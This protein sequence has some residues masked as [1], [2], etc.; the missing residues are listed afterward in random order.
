VTP[1]PAPAPAD[2]PHLPGP[3]WLFCPADRPDRFTKA[4][5]RAD[6]VI[7]D[8]EDAVAADRKDL[9]RRAVLDTP[10]DPARVMVRVNPVDSPE[11]AADLAAVADAGYRTVMVPKVGAARD[12]DHLDGL[13]VVALV[14][15]AS[16]VFHALEIAR[17][18]AV[19][20]VMWGAEDLVASLGGK[21]SRGAD[22]GYRDVCRQARSTVLLACGAAGV[23]A[24]DS[25]YL[26]VT[27]P[28]GPADEA[29]DA[30][31]SGFAYKACIHPGHVAAVRAAF[32]PT[33]AEVDRARRVLAAARST[34]VT[35]VDGQMVD[36]P[37]IRQ[38]ERVITV[39]GS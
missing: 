38:A 14:E 23:D 3:A 20:A 30:A 13:T 32:T 19:T 15:T 36:A 9:A 34:G 4:L 26:D 22:G 2:T 25:V 31:A 12:L 11:H 7:L 28:E 37:L 18:P 17:H 10:L 29:A 35:T 1:T 8:L 27:R 21:S 5:D 24:V 6:L 16:G 39:A 33:T